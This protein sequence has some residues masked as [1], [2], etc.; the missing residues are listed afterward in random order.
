M[1]INNKKIFLDYL[2]NGSVEKEV[3][4]SL[5]VIY[6]DFK[7]ISKINIKDNPKAKLKDF[8][9]AE[10]KVNDYYDSDFRLRDSWIEISNEIIEWL[11]EDIA[12]DFSLSTHDPM[13]NSEYFKQ[14]TTLYFT[15]I[16]NR[17][18]KDVITEELIH[19]NG[20]AYIR[21]FLKSNVKFV[22]TIGTG[23]DGV[24]QFEPKDIDKL[25]A[26]LYQIESGVICQNYFISVI[27]RVIISL[28][29]DQE[30]NRVAA[31]RFNQP[32]RLVSEIPASKLT[33]I[34][35]NMNSQSNI[36]NIESTNSISMNI[37][38]LLNSLNLKT[39]FSIE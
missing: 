22:I 25:E 37:R 23:I 24:L 1:N 18:L 16:E 19:V 20:I 6:A 39:D 5:N 11:K 35:D 32:N 3:F 8:L 29:F 30:L 31:I 14:T 17:L 2:Y 7:E 10:L 38:D 26:L 33:D 21:E 4:A 27:F 12:K 9:D 15:E 34:F 36:K 28:P 13:F